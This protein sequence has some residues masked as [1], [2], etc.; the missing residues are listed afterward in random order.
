MNIVLLYLVLLK[1]TVTSFSG[2]TSLPVAQDALVNQYHVLTNDQLN[3]AVIT[4]SARAM[5]TPALLVI[6]WC[7][8]SGARLNDPPSLK[9]SDL[10]YVFWH[11]GGPICRGGDTSLKR[12][13][14]S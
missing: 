14:P 11:Q 1:A 2:S 5:I 12:L 4:L 6:P 10:K 9:W 3:E 8:F 13:L 7:I